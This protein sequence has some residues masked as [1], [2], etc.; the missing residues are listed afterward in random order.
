MAEKK[1]IILRSASAI[2]SYPWWAGLAVLVGVELAREHFGGRYPFID[3]LAKALL[4]ALG[5][6]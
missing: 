6:V 1:G 2:R 5:G 3:E 4:L